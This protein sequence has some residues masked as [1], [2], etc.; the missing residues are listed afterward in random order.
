MTYAVIFSPEFEEQ[1]SDQAVYLVRRGASMAVAQRYADAIT[2]YC[3]SLSDFP[4]RGTQRDDIRAGL[5]ITHYQ[6][7]AVIAFAVDDAAA[8]VSIIG[9]FFGGQDYE[10]ELREGK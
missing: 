4:H 2:A 3:A 8:D 9:V 7:R 10:T 5:R 6:G 1:L